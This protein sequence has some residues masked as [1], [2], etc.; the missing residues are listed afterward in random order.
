MHKV[1]I[2]YTKPTS[3][4]PKVNQF[5]KIH[6]EFELIADLNPDQEAVTLGN[7]SITYRE[8]NA[9]ANGLA[10][11]LIQKGI[12][13]E[14]IVAIKLD[15]SIEMV[16][17]IL[18]IM[19]AG[20][21]YLPIDPT[22]PETRIDYML[23]DSETK[24]MI[25]S[26]DSL[27]NHKHIYQININEPIEPTDH[28]PTIATTGQSLAYMIYTSGST[29]TPKGVMVEH[30]G[31][32]NMCLSQ[33]IT[34]DLAPNE[35]VLQFASISFDASVYEIFIALLSGATLVLIPKSHII[36][37]QLFLDY[38]DDQKLTFVLLPPVFL[39]SLERPEFKTVKTIVTA[40]EACNV[41]DAIHYSH[42]KKYFNAYGP[43]EAS[44]CISLYQV[45]PHEAYENYIPV[46][47]SIPNMKFYIM[48]EHM[49][50]VK[51]GEPGELCVAGVGLARGYKNKPELTKGAFID[52]PNRTG[53]RLYKTGDIVK[54]L[55]DGNIVVFGRKDQQVKIAGHRIELGAIEFSMAHNK[56]IKSV[57]VDVQQ[58]NNEKYLCAYYTASE[59]LSPEWIR[60]QLL[61]E[62]PSFMIPHWFI[63]I[64][65]FKITKNG[66]IDKS[67]L[68]SPFE[69][70]SFTT[71]QDHPNLGE[72]EKKFLDI[73]KEILGINNIMPTDNFFVIG[74]HSLKAA[75]LCV[76][77]SKEFGIKLSVADIYKQPKIQDI[78]QNIQKNKKTTYNKL[79]HAPIQKYY[80][81]SAAQKRMYVMNSTD[82]IDVS[83]NVSIVLRFE[84][85]ISQSAVMMA[86]KQ[87]TQRHEV[88]RTRFDIQYDE[89]V[90]QILPD[91]EI[92]LTQG[93]IDLTEMDRIA[94]EFVRPFDLNAAP[95]LRIGYYTIQQGG[96]AIIFDTHHIIADGTSMGILAKEFVQLLEG[97]E[98]KPV[99]FQ[100]KD[101]AEWEKTQYGQNNYFKEHEQFWTKKYKTIPKWDMPTDYS[102][103]HTKNFEGSRISME[104]NPEISA[105]IK[106]YAL[107]HDISIY[108]LLLTNYYLLLS[109]YTQ[110]QDLVIG[111]AVAN[112]QKD[113]IQ[114]MM[115]MFVNILPLRTQVPSQITFDEFVQST[116]QMVLESF[117]H[118]EYPFE[119]LVSKLGLSGNASKIPLID[120]LF[121]VQN[122]NFFNDNPIEGLQMKYENATAT[123]K[124]D[125]SFFI[126]ERKETFL[127][128]VEYN[129]HLYK[130]ET[131]SK[132][133][134]SYIQILERA[135][136]KPSALLADI[137]LTTEE[138]MKKIKT[139]I[140]N[141]D[142][143]I[144]D[145]EFD[146]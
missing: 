40:G 144:D 81:T 118:Q 94:N 4:T 44:V 77:I 124:F 137:P 51:Q 107:D 59:Q 88:F 63:Q 26:A 135:L 34:Y 130:H 116:K 27:G 128:E 50:P 146:L 134:Q 9:R 73:C 92:E 86:L 72:V 39:N 17:A 13:Q 29:G 23:E 75:S 80:A 30:R 65:E 127:I 8:L 113:E 145:I 115:G 37:R 6:S 90:Q 131:I 18:G 67:V 68:P 111:T 105:I 41:S 101:Y 47:K 1:S 25:T 97:Q 32:V 62:L 84:R 96:V 28:N 117:E 20:A 103:T 11:K 108:Q 114:E 109:K 31:F 36:D 33:I 132:L 85:T 45:N 119:S 60:E 87:L 91:I 83:Y 99:H 61:Q 38:V 56:K 102:K 122:I 140:N 46:G 3:F 16:I 49:K 82:K 70:N 74:G 104:I 55:N 48:D 21:A 66:K 100:Y 53:E 71:P 57:L 35:R 93:A 10:Y 98:L 125:F 54:E 15:R 139:I 5:F 120:T 106:K 42:S 52:N 19:K 110:Q 78:L 76:K 95:I 69:I 123:S 2:H 126:V 79:T 129:T 143:Q 112:R 141:D 89:I 24:Y 14:E 142:K 12:K 58:H 121:V 22:Y 7:T 43:T 136:T 133:T 138:D 64:P